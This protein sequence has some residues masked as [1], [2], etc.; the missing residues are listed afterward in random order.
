MR[1]AD[2]RIESIR[3]RGRGRRGDGAGLRLKSGAK[4]LAPMRSQRKCCD[5]SA[6]CPLPRGS[7]S[8]DYR[9]RLQARGGVEKSGHLFAAQNRRKFL[10]LTTGGDDLVDAPGPLQRDFVKKADGRDADQDRACGESPLECQM[11][12]IGS[13][14]GW[15]RCNRRRCRNL[16]SGWCSV[17]RTRRCSHSQWISCPYRSPPTSWPTLERRL[18]GRPRRSRL[19]PASRVT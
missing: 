11:N 9:S 7:P 1:R 10:R 18:S 6:L 16:R 14:L 19:M 3:N 17:R 12:L 4:L 5:L 8:A 15:C 2:E 13:D